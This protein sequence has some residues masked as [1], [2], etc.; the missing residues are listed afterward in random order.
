MERYANNFKPGDSFPTESIAVIL[1][2]MQNVIRKCANIFV[3]LYHYEWSSQTSEA[4]RKAF[5]R[6]ARRC[7]RRYLRNWTKKVPKNPTEMPPKT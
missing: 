5:I 2:K 1:D 4:A 3:K 7:C 6:E